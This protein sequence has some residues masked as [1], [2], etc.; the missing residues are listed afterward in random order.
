M[1]KQTLEKM[2]AELQLARLTIVLAHLAWLAEGEA[3]AA[4]MPAEVNSLMLAFAEQQSAKVTESIQ[5]IDERIIDVQLAIDLYD[6]LA[7]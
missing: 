6:L 2:L 4:D 7:E 5:K 1:D 3:I